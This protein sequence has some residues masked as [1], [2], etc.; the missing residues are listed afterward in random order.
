MDAFLKAWD[1]LPTG[2]F[3]GLYQS[4]RYGVTKTERSGGRQGWIWAEERGG[5]D[6]ISANL[7]RLQ[8]G[9]KLKPC[10]MPAEKVF[11]FVLGVKP[12]SE[13]SS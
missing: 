12:L 8:S 7:Y 1:A 3:E 6:T 10:E 11:D 2:T 9:A 13:L 5:S 4:R